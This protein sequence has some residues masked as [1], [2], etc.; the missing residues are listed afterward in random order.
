MGPLT[1]KLRAKHR[2]V[3]HGKDPQY[4]GFLT[5]VS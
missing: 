3:L 5:L 1:E 4:Q 2:E